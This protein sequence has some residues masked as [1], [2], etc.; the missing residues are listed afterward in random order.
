MSNVTVKLIRGASY[1]TP[2]GIKV[3]KTKPL[4]LATSDPSIAFYRRYP[5]RFSVTEGTPAPRVPMR[6]RRSAPPP[7]ADTP[8]PGPPKPAALT[9]QDLKALKKADLVDLAVAAGC[10]VSADDDTKKTL[11]AKILKAEGTSD[12]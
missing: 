3:L 6:R 10:P 9:E 5:K 1:T 7:E 11:I 8:S 4:L 2:F 12:A